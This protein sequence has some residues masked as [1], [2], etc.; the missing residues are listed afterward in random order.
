[1]R[2]VTSRAALFAIALA[3]SGCGADS[4]TVTPDAGDAAP[5]G[6][7]CADDLAA[8]ALPPA[9]PTAPAN[10]TGTRTV[11]AVSRLDL[12]DSP[13]DSWRSTGYDLDG[14]ISRS[15]DANH[16]T[17]VEGASPS[18]MTDLAGGIDN[19]WGANLLPLE[20]SV[21]ADLSTEVT[22]SIQSGKAPC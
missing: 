7:S 20:Q 8:C 9:P 16:C 22:A 18:V 4:Q 1:M 3:A 17:L 14:L 11:I 13:P 2:A 12:G 5:L 6:A 19:S 15:G 10:T 21:A